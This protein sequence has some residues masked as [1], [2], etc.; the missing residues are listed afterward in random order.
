MAGRNEA[1]DPKK[2]LVGTANKAQ[3][4][5]PLQV[6]RFSLS[7]GGFQAGKRGPEFSGGQI[8][9]SAEAAAEFGVAQAAVAV[10]RAYKFHSVALCL[11]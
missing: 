1:I 8:I 6:S 7:S 11:Q 2:I 4:A 5:A 9:Q 10:E 3:H